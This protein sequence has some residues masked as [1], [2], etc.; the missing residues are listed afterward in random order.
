MF[1]Q[2]FFCLP[3]YVAA[4]IQDRL[5]I[6]EIEYNLLEL[7]LVSLKNIAIN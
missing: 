4:F 7:E 6:Q 2:F 1:V 3:F 5:E